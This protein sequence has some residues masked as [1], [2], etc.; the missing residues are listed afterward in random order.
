MRGSLLSK[1]RTKKNIDYPGITIFP[2]PGKNKST[3]KPSNDDSACHENRGFWDNGDQTKVSETR[4]FASPHQRKNFLK[5]AISS[6]CEAGAVRTLDRARRVLPAVNSTNVASSLATGNSDHLLESAREIL[7]IHGYRTSSTCSS[8]QPLS[9]IN[10]TFSEQKTVVALNKAVTDEKTICPSSRV[11]ALRLR[12]RG[13]VAS[14]VTLADVHEKR[15]AAEERKVKE[16]EHVRDELESR[17]ERKKQKTEKR[18]VKQQQRSESKKEQKELREK[19][20]RKVK[21]RVS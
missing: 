13:K 16:L 1:F 10:P 14:E 21:D 11:S 12:R 3:R 8:T 7:A 15:C 5:D 4:S 19:C 18:K 2:E 9:S 17:I 20:V 6:Q